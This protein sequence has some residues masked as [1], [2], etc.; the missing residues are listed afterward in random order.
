MTQAQAKIILR[1][2]GYTMSRRDGE[3]R[4]AP[5]D[6][7]PSQKEAR[8]HY[9]DDLGDAIGTARF[10][11]ARTMRCTAVANHRAV[12]MMER[13]GLADWLSDSSDWTPANDVTDIQP[14]AF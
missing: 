8:A 6:G 14:G 11:V 3:Y 9:T 7:T 13:T 10:E 2:L 4:V 1:T 12:R 5:M